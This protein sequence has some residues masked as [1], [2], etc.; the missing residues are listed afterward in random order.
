ML[1]TDRCNHVS[2]R[3]HPK[4]ASVRALLIVLL[5]IVG[6][7]D[8]VLALPTSP[9]PQFQLARRIR[10]TPFARTDVSM[11]DSEGSAYVP[12]DR[13]L[14]LADDNGRRI[15]EVN[16]VTGALKR[17][18][19][20]HR[21][22]NVRRFGGGPTAGAARTLDLESMAYDRAHDALYVFSG[23]CCSSSVQPTV[24]RLKRNARGKLFV[25]SYQPLAGSA[26]YT[27][28]A[29]NAANGKIYVGHGHDLR[30]Y[31]YTTNTAG[32]TF[33]VPNLTAITGMSFSPDGASLFVT[34]Y[35]EQFRRV[36]W[37]TKKLVSGWTFDLTRFGI[38]DARAVE[39][40]GGRF[41]VS[42]GD[43]MRSDAD[44]RKYMV[45]VFTVS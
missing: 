43:D 40:I 24:F 42:D 30:T 27:A 34:T 37:S 33:R 13:S 9:N 26:N 20:R 45:Y 10:T 2:R 25:E 5:A 4:H 32:Q 38:N 12:R 36:R 29:W 16:P 8:L 28:A 41:Y 44:P 17:S 39:Y 35:H 1:P 18:I 3:R 23:S 21:F 22:E 11:Q 14:W 15:Y 6:S 19:G 7:H 31:S